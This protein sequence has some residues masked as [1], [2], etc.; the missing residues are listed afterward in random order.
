M[1]TGAAAISQGTAPRAGNTGVLTG[2]THHFQA[3]EA[4]E[5]QNLGEADFCEMYQRGM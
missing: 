3:L 5:A 4:S 2:L 1:T